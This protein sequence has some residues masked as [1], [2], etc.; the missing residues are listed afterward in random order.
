MPLDRCREMD[1]SAAPE[2]AVGMQLVH[3]RVICE[4]SR[5]GRVY[6]R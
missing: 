3:L 2:R 4:P 1:L 6:A 5:P